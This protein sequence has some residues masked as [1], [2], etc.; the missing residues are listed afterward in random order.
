MIKIIR[1]GISVSVLTLLSCGASAIDVKEANRQALQAMA[2]AGDAHDGGDFGRSKA[3]F[4]RASDLF[5][6][7]AAYAK[8]LEIGMLY[9]MYRSQ[10]SD[11]F[12][13][14]SM[15]YGQQ[16]EILKLINEP[17]TEDTAN[18]RKSR[19]Q[20]GISRKTRQEAA[21]SRQEA[22]QFHRADSKSSV[23]QKK[24]QGLPRSASSWSQF[25]GRVKDMFSRESSDSQVRSVRKPLKELSPASCK[26]GAPCF[27]RQGSEQDRED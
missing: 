16:E 14:I 10:D 2:E 23:A 9:Q 19:I 13:S 25:S 18:I 22:V 8:Q 3:S 6:R 20:G 5:L 27:S 1:I 26:S 21:Q 17:T 24:S 4:S 7:L 15:L 12:D 11:D